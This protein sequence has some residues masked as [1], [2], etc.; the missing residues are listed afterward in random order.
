[1]IASL[2]FSQKLK[3]CQVQVMSKAVNQLN[4]RKI[5]FKTCYKSILSHGK[6][7]PCGNNDSILNQKII[8]YPCILTQYPLTPYLEHTICIFMAIDYTANIN[9]HICT[10]MYVYMCSM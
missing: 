9:N 8:N 2:Q 6:D 10:S 7:S 1:M 5:T 3:H 4:L